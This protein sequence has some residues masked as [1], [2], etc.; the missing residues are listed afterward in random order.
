MLF[1]L[2]LIVEDA[3]VHIAWLWLKS[4]EREETG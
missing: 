2:H 1:L 4:G 3:A